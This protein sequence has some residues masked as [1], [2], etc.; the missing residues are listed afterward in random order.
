MAEPINKVIVQ[1]KENTLETYVE[2]KRRSWLFFTVTHEEVIKTES[3]G[4]EI[5]IKSDREI[6]QIYF[7]GKPL[8]NNK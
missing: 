6:S 7:N 8:L 4:N 1:G 5:H 2:K 3:L